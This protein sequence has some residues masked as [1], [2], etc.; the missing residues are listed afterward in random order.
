MEVGG[1]E[2]K[3]KR[4]DRNIRVYGGR[5]VISATPETETESQIQGQPEQLSEILSQNKKWK[6]AKDEV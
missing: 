4:K 5:P 2:G 1:I 3:K 6:G